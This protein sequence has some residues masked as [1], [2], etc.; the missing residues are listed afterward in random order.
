MAIDL[1]AIRK[2]LNQ[3]SGN[4][5]KRNSMWRPQEGEDHTVRILA[6]SDNDG[7]PYKERCF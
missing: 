3:L 1:D 2:K 4:N 6:F 5:S 7:Q